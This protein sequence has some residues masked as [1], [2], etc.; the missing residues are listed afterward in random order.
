VTKQITMTITLREG[1]IELES[2]DTNVF[3]DPLMDYLRDQI[4]L[5]VER[6]CPEQLEET[7]DVMLSYTVQYHAW[8]F[9][10]SAYDTLGEYKE[11]NLDGIMISCEQNDKKI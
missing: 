3:P 4:Y 9:F 5:L 2:Y 7:I 6:D 10:E 1:D 11:A 8:P